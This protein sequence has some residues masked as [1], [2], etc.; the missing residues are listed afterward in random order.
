ME[1]TGQGAGLTA[2][3]IVSSAFYWPFSF[4]DGDPSGFVHD[5]KDPRTPDEF[6]IP[7]G[8][9]TMNYRA[10]SFSQDDNFCRID[11]NP[12]TSELAVQFFDWDGDPIETRKKNDKLTNAPERLKLAKW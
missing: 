8:L 11:I 6:T 4:A 2:Y 5:S 12:D 7:E 10:W 3:S 9:G 1:F